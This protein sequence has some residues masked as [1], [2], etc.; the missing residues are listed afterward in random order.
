[1][2]DLCYACA[3]RA[4]GLLDGSGDPSR[5]T[6]AQAIFVG[7]ATPAPREASWRPAEFASGLADRE[8][9]DEVGDGGR[10]LLRALARIGERKPR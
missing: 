4:A 3:K 2:D 5:L 10:A 1:V 8:R 7:L 6:P 9:R